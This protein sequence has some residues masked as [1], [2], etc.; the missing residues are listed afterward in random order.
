MS[1]SSSQQKDSRPVDSLLS[2]FAFNGQGPRENTLNK[3]HRLLYF[4]FPALPRIFMRVSGAC[5]CIRTSLRALLL[6]TLHRPNS[7]CL[8]RLTRPNGPSGPCSSALSPSS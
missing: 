3:L 6:R 1:R 5:A 7:L 8:P 2:S 4:L